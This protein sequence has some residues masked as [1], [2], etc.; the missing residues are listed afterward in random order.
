MKMKKR[1]AP[2]TKDEILSLF[3]KIDALLTSRH[4]EMAITVLGGVSIILQGIRDRATADI[5]IVPSQAAN[6]FVTACAEFGIPVDIVTVAST[7]DLPHAPKVKLFEG[8]SLRVDSIT[9]EDLIKLKLE[10]FRKHDPEDIY[11][12]LEK[13]AVSYEHFKGLVQDMLPDFIGNPREILLSAFIV[14]ERMYP[15]KG[16]DFKRLLNP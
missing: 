12:M 5:D 8:T 14:V 2:V 10:R 1:Y 6:R 7:V 16:G 13:K 11:A 3:A 9:L 4:Q 15:E